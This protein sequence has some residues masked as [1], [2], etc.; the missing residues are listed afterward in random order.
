MTRFFDTLTDLDK[1]KY[2]KELKKDI[3]IE[4]HTKIK[5]FILN[6][7]LQITNIKTSPL[8]LKDKN[9][10]LILDNS[11]NKWFVLCVDGKVSLVAKKN[12]IIHLSGFEYTKRDISFSKKYKLNNID[13]LIEYVD[14]IGANISLNVLAYNDII[15]KGKWENETDEIYKMSIH[16]NVNPDL[17]GYTYN[18]KDF[19]LC[20]IGKNS[21][22]ENDILT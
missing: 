2:L 5:D 7:D 13:Y 21:Y 18:G 10:V 8:N 1:E 3:N 19:S 12:I 20:S 4:E 6:N 22:K 14:N 16:S 15:G 9:L 17:T 11:N